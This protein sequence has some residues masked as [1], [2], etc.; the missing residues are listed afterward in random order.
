LKRRTLV[1]RV[2]LIQTVVALVALA[3]VALVTSVTVTAVLTRKTDDALEQVSA[4]VAGVVQE[5]QSQQRNLDWVQREIQEL[6]PVGMRVEVRDQRGALWVSAGEAIS[7][8][9]SSQGCADRS[10]LRTCGSP[11]G[12]FRVCGTRAAGFT[13]LTAV[14]RAPDLNARNR[15]VGVLG[16]ACVLAGLAITIATRWTTQRALAPFSELAE[17]IAALDPGGGQRLGLNC[18]LAELALLEERFDELVARFDEALGREKRLAAHASHELRTPLTVARAEIE[19]VARG[20]ARAAQALAALDRLSDLV[21]SLLWFARAQN[22]LDSAL[23]A[24]VNVADVVRSQAANLP[25]HLVP[26]VFRLPDEAL[27]RGDEHLLRRITAN[28]LDNSLKYGS[29]TLIEIEAKRDG[30]TLRLAIANGGGTVEPEGRQLI[31]EPFQRGSSGG[32][33]VPGFGLGL[34]FARAVAR[35]HGGDLELAASGG[36]R[37]EFVLTLPLLAWSAAH[38]DMPT[39]EGKPSRQE[40]HASGVPPVHQ[41]GSTDCGSPVRAAR[42][43]A[44]VS[45]G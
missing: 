3:M 13:I 11:A 28:L 5:T 22:R 32:A 18:D 19:A 29:G 24:V 31:F 43:E 10:V 30:D 1:D 25:A 20:D 34:P 44:D 14:D 40:E 42:S 7:L 4:R 26:F 33:D 9:D 45:S 35:A 16:A 12:I 15:L 38:A 27:V 23:M 17:R 2:G 41:I 36:S 6:K 37:T 21:E 8:E 39:H